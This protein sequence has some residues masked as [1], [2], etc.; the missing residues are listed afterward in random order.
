MLRWMCGHTIKDRV[1]NEIIQEKVGV[2]SIEGK[3]RET[4]CIG[5]DTYKED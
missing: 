5:L 3:M 2:T 4:T 1:M